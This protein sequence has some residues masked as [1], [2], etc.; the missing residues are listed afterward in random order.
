MLLTFIAMDF[1]FP[2]NSE[3]LDGRGRG[4]RDRAEN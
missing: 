3:Y 4:G 2:E 1:D